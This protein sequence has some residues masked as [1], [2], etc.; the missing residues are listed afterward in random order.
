[1]NR[2][3]LAVCVAIAGA[4]RPADLPATTRRLALRDITRVASVLAVVGPALDAE[5]KPKAAAPYDAPAAGNA[6]SGI[7]VDWGLAAGPDAMTYIPDSLKLLKHIEYAIKQKE[8]APYIVE[9]N[10]NMKRE[11]AE[12]FADYAVAKS[13]KQPKINDLRSMVSLLATQYTQYGF[14]R[15]IPA[16][17]RDKLLIDIPKIRAALMDA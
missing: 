15:P 17:V 10:K 3:I 13:G 5:A 14:Q 1:M 16:Q 7:P 6:P 2:T 4:L 9:V 12:Y 11:C 8:D